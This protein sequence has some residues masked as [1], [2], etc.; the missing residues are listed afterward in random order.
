LRHFDVEPLSFNALL[1]SSNSFPDE[2]PTLCMV[3]DNGLLCI[4]VLRLFGDKGQGHD[5][6]LTAFALSR[7]DCHFG[8]CMTTLIP[9]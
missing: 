6:A 8:Q 9:L 2:M 1:I 4:E 5:N 3:F 7:N